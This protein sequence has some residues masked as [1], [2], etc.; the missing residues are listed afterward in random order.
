[1]SY[2]PLG[3]SIANIKRYIEKSDNTRS[4]WENSVTEISPEEFEI[5]C[6]ELLRSMKNDLQE[7]SIE[8]NKIYVTNSG[9]Y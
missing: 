5:Y 1:M 6:L 4:L 2:N 7:F 3:G 9:Q 8:H